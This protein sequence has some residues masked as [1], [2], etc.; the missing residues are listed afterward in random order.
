MLVKYRRTLFLLYALLFGVLIADTTWAQKPAFP[1]LKKTK[2]YHKQVAK[3][4]LLKLVELKAT[5]PEIV[6]DLRYATTNNFTGTLLY[7]SGESTYLRLL[8]AR[9]L[10]A[11]QSELK[12]EGLGLKIF[13]AYRPYSVTVKM[14]D[15]IKDERYVANPA[16]GSGHNRGLAVDLTLIHLATGQEL[17]MGTAFDNFTDTAH[18]VF[19]SLPDATLKNREK[20]KTIME[21]HGF[22]ALPT[23]W[24]HYY[25]TNDGRYGVMDL[26]FRNLRK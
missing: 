23:E 2:L 7:P 22:T 9:E 21:K 24:W 19:R 25:W 11:I 14:W 6:Y 17:D 13:D 10:A 26:E 16:K 20:L 12:E 3:D 18:H 1:V 4:S 8:P 5:I 15:L